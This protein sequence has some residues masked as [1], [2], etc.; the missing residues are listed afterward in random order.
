MSAMSVAPQDFAADFKELHSIVKE[1]YSLWKAKSIR[2]DAFYTRLAQRISSGQVKTKEDYGH[3]LLEYFGALQNSHSFVFF[4]TFTAGDNLACI[5]GSLFVDRPNEYLRKHGF[6]DKDQIIALNNQNIHTWMQQNKGLTPASTTFYRQQRTMK[7][8]F[9]SM[10]D[11]IRTFTLLRSG[12]TLSISLP[13]VRRSLFKTQKTADIEYRTLM[14]SIAYIA[15]HSLQGNDL[16]NHFRQVLAKASKHQRLIIDLRHCADGGSENADKITRY[17]IQSP[18]KGCL[19]GEKLMPADKCFNGKAIVLINLDTFGAAEVLALN[20][21]ECGSLMLM[22]EP[23]AGDAGCSPRCFKT[24]R[25]TTFSLA[26]A[27]PARSP[28]GWPLEGSSIQPSF[29]SVPTSDFFLRGIDVQ[30]EDALMALTV[31][32]EQH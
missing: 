29:Y 5:K 8:A 27:P 22:G 10:T 19:S 13:L 15:F 26:T 28:K 25:G 14:D 11:S 9:S 23:T 1:N 30:I 2:L 21:R 17:L 7:G 3:L 18:Q 24:S 12:D 32:P 4:D 16:E 31:S 6:R 20:L